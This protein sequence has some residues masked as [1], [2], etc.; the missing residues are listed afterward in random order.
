ME[1]NKKYSLNEI[2]TASELVEK[3]AYD[4]DY[5]L[6]LAKEHL[7]E[8]K[9]YRTDGRDYLFTPEAVGILEEE[10]GKRPEN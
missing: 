1:S 6:L 2:M 8:G 10:I 9:D 5:L 7:T 3:L 4:E